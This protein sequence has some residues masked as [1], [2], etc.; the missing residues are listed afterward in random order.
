MPQSNSFMPHTLEGEKGGDLKLNGKRR[1][2]SHA[3]A[4]SGNLHYST[5]VR[6]NEEK[7]KK[8]S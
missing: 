7:G 5:I 1:G 2:Q 4:T 3:G 8:R 6:L